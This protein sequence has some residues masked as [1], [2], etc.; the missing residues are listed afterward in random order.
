MTSFFNDNLCQINVSL[1]DFFI[2]PDFLPHI[3]TGQG[4]RVNIIMLLYVLF[5]EPQKTPKDLANENGHMEVVVLLEGFEVFTMYFFGILLKSF[6]FSGS[7]STAEC[8]LI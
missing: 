4:N 7:T 8:K 2:F 1:S 6:K 5:D 3:P